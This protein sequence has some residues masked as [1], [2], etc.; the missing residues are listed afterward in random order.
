MG[1]DYVNDSVKR[2]AAWGKIE[3]MSVPLTNRPSAIYAQVIEAANGYRCRGKNGTKL[4]DFA[5]TGK[6]Q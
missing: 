1:S 6:Q 4:V 5:C 3:P 2:P